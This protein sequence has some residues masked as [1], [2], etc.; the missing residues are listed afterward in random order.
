MT[1]ALSSYGEKVLLYDQ[2]EIMQH[3]SMIIANKNI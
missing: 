2:M 1:L 3:M